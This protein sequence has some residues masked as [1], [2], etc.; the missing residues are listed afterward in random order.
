MKRIVYALGNAKPRFC[1]LS[2]GGVGGTG[3]PFWNRAGRL[4]LFNWGHSS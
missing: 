1:S 2:T 4:Y 3:G